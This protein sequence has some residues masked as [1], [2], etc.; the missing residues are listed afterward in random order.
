MD[1]LEFDQGILRGRREDDAHALCSFHYVCI[2]DDV[3]IRID[4]DAGANGMPAGD[5]PGLVSVIF[6]GAIAAHNDLD[7]GG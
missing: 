1:G 2:G 6:D 7:H 5:S 3:A 4:D